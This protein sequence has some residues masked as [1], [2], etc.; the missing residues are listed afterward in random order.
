MSMNPVT[1]LST[2]VQALGK[3][4][5]YVT[6]TPTTAGT[7]Q[8]LGITEGEIQVNEKYTFNDYKLPEWTG[9]AIHARNVDGQ[10]LDITVPLIWG[11]PT[12][13]DTISPVGAKGGGRSAPTAVTSR[14]VCVIPQVEVGSGIS[15][16]GTS[17]SP[18]APNHA[19]WLHKATF[20]PGV[21]GFK[22]ADGG[23]IIR[24]MTIHAMFDDTKP[25]GQKLYTI[26]NPVTQGIT[27][28]RV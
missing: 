22:N 1:S 19:V 13:Y 9:E 4:Y 6:S 12:L 20:E 17:W 28:Y 18:A 11:D 8:L 14:T 26:G 16:N 21:Y 3:A 15:Y 23:K 25:E 2:Y 7:W 5:I 24:P 10:G 27:T